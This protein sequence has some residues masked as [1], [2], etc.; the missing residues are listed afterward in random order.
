MTG[1]KKEEKPI[2]MKDVLAVKPDVRPDVQQL[3]DNLKKNQSKLEEL[4]KEV[5]GEWCYEDGVYRFYHQSLKVYYLQSATTKMVEALQSLL[6]GRPL[7][8]WFLEIVKDG[9]RK[10]FKLEHN[11]EW[12][13]HARPIVEAFFHAKYFLEMGVS[14]A[15]T[16][17]GPVNWLPSGWAGFLYLY[18]LR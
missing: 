3:W 1:K 12:L 9:T 8:S 4:L 17:D 6:P 7:N 2:D 13:K 16:M 10:E 14:S 5:L 18:N 15:K 11:R